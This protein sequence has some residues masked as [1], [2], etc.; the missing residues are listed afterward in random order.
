LWTKTYGVGYGNCVI[1]T[2]D[3]GYAIVGRE[4][5]VY[6]RSDLC[7]IKTNIMGDS[8]WSKTYGDSNN[9]DMGYSVRETPDNGFI[10]VGG[11]ES[12][13]AGESDLWLVKTDE[14]G[15]T[16]WTKTYGGSAT[17]VGRC[18]QLSNDGGYIIAGWTSSYGAGNSDVWLL[19]T[20]LNGDTLWTRTFG[21]SLLQRGYFVIQTADS[22]YIVSGY[23]GLLI[24][25]DQYGNNI[26]IKTLM[27][28]SG[29]LSWEITTIRCV[30]EIDNGYIMSYGDWGLGDPIGGLIKTNTMGD[31][32]WTKGTGDAY[33][34]I[35]QTY[36]GEFLAGGYTGEGLFI[37][38]HI[39]LYDSLGT[40]IWT[41][42]PTIGVN[43]VIQSHD[44]SYLCTGGLA[45]EKF[46][47]QLSNL[48]NSKNNT[49][50][51]YSLS[52]NFP[53]PFNPSTTIEFDIQKT[54]EVSLKVFNI[55]GEEVTTLV[56]DR[57]P[58]GSYSYEWDASSLASGIYLYRLQAE[59][60]IQTRKMILMK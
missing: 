46:G 56:S 7:L 24:K 38:G 5:D 55:L 33:Y 21:D 31:T 45:L 9:H 49:I 54:S 30:R 35:V 60:F 28:S 52:Q 17:D 22:G 29:N 4:Y 42:G 41:Y 1:K 59:G 25:T 34:S 51:D 32:I 18:I 20:D 36:N 39:G 14:N 2:S 43:S 19:K 53:N 16:L 15:D 57:L 13:G 26:W 11:T 27:N 3:S 40:N 12:Y 58:A 44:S 6:G 23:R 10:I 48:A 50:N 37:F 47:W 8:L